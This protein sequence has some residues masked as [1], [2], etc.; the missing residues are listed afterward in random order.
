MKTATRFDLLEVGLIAWALCLIT[1]VL[2]LRSFSGLETRRSPTGIVSA[3]V[4]QGPEEWIVRD[5]FDDARGGVFVDVGASDHRDNSNTW[6]LET[7]LGWSGVAIDA[8]AQY[9]DGYR[10]NRPRTLFVPVF[11]S[12]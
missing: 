8:Q 3:K 7:Y 11:V 6:R 12:E 1:M 5:F 2:T 9:A 4:S 10:T